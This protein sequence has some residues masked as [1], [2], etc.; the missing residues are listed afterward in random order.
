MIDSQQ[1]DFAADIADCANLVFSGHYY[2]AD[3]PSRR[4]LQV[5]VHGVSY[6]HRYWDAGRINGSDYSYVRYMT[7]RGYDILAMDLPGTG[8]S[9]RPNG[10]SVTI[11]SV[12]KALANVIETVRG[13][14]GPLE[15]IIDQ[16]ALVGHSLGT[17]VSVYTQAWWQPAD[18]VVATGT[19]Y[20]PWRDPSAFGPNGREEAMKD[21]YACPTPELRRRAFYY[22]PMADPEVVEFD[23]RF[24]RT[25]MPRRL[26]ADALQARDDLAMA[27]ISEVS[28]PVYVQLGEHDLIM[29]GSLARQERECW[30]AATEVI[31]EQVD[32]IGHCLNLHLNHVGG[33]QAIDRFLSGRNNG[34]DI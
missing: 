24:L 8:S 18:L 16:V 1:I 7:E 10:D 17:I 14:G 3:K 28:C 30:P 12:G 22:E 25:S 4:L 11:E 34:R 21:E 26:W 31:V 9:P 2:P 19:G 29:P 20:F 5:L 27:G 23:N 33:W 15:T 6:D 13:S 32:A